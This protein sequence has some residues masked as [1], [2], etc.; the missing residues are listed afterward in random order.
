MELES[1]EYEI[2]ITVSRKMMLMM[3]T[4]EILECNITSLFASHAR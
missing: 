1:N 2:K 3:M 4:K